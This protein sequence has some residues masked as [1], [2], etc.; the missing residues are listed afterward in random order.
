MTIAFT[1]PQTVKEL[2]IAAKEIISDERRFTQGLL[3]QGLD[4][5]S[6]PLCGNTKACSLGA[7][8]LAAYGP[9]VKDRFVDGCQITEISICGSLPRTVEA[10]RLL[11]D[12]A[13]EI[14]GDESYD[15]SYDEFEYAIVDLNDSPMFD[16]PETRE[17]AYARLLRAF[18]V[19][20]SRAPEEPI[21]T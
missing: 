1:P 4:A 16:D 3:F 17:E 8:G 20:I 19:A 12:A 2:L 18:D 6:D 5:D 7:L 9:A 10:A 15:E 11:N 21:L 14:V 13:E